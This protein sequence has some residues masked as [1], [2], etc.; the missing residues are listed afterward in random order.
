MCHLCGDSLAQDLDYDRATLAL[1]GV[2]CHYCSSHVDTCPHP[3]GCYRADYLNS[4]PAAGL[5]LRYNA[6][7]NRRDRTPR[8]IRRPHDQG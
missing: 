6:G 8:G 4:P 1:R 2:L 5:G 3:D 7:G